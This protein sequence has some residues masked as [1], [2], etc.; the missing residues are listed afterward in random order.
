MNPND[1]GARRSFLKG[2]IATPLVVAGTGVLAPPDAKA[3]STSR[4]PSTTTEPYL[5][6][7]IA[8]VKLVAILTTGDSVGGYR[9]VGIPDGLGP[10]RSGHKEFTLLMN[11]ELTKDA[12]S[13]PGKVR[14]HGSDG[15]FVSRWTINSETLKVLKGQDHTQSANGVHTWDIAAKSYKSGTTQWQRYCSG[16]LAAESAYYAHGRGT[17][18]RIYLNGEEV[19]D[20]RGWARVC[21][22]SHTGEAWQLPRLGRMAFENAVACPF[23][24][25]KTIVACQDDS[26]AST[27]PPPQ[28][29]GSEVYFYIG[30]KQTS[31]HPIE[32][33]GLT[34]GWLYGVKMSV[35]G[36]AVAG[37]DNLYGLGDAATGYIGKGRFELVNLFDVSSVATGL[38]FETLSNVN[39][40]TRVQRCEDGAWD[41]RE[42]HQHNYYFVTTASIT[43]NSRLWRLRFDD[44]EHPEN[45][46][47]VE[48]LLRGDEGH[49]MLDNVTIDHLGRV[50]MDEDPGGNDRVARIWL[51]A[52]S[53]R[54]FI[55]VAAH[56]PRFFDPDSKKPEFI[57]NDEESSGIIDV[58]HLLGEGW[59]LLDVQSHKVSADPELVEGGQLLAMWIDPDIGFNGSQHNR[60]DDHERRR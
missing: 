11:H 21:T 35:D 5:K 17:Q 55:Q 25:E 44:I 60:H 14:A 6:P 15:A 52:I 51:Y 1:L 9:M 46:G 58:A 56:N 59:F 18:E 19:T 39:G 36:K 57:T 23:P 29:N 10:F 16:D 7:S 12:P 33:A 41:P 38:E 47:T 28:N 24:Q 53:T 49:R 3:T 13:G 31:G 27:A 30:T 2:A 37:E 43:T 22:G 34:N 8:G 48:I 50:V 26:S 45:G 42:K 4:G 40:V 32:R 54:E 20:G